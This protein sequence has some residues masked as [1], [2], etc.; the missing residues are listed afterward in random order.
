[1]YKNITDHDTFTLVGQHVVETKETNPIIMAA[2][3]QAASGQTARTEMTGSLGRP[4][5]F[6]VAVELDGRNGDNS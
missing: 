4:I 6:G 2:S 3:K 5:T 1:V